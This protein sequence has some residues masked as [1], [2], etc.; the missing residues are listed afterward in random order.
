MSHH[1]E[2]VGGLR[3]IARR[4]ASMASE[5]SDAWTASAKRE[6]VLAV[7]LTQSEYD[8]LAAAAAAGFRTPAAQVRWMIETYCRS[9]A[10]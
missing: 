6:K 2:Q 1:D 4:T 7:K 5:K 9:E 10:R 3:G 8:K